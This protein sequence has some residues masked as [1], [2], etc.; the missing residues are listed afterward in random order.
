LDDNFYKRPAWF[1]ARSKAI[2]RWKSS[3]LPCAVCGQ[4]INWVVKGSMIVDHIVNRK[5]RPDL[6]LE[7]TNL[8]VVH[9]PCNTKKAL[10]K[11]NTTREEIGLDGLPASWR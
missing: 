2:A 3:G 7:P 11:E 6:A 1:K 4:P 9:H 10:W 5:K 8:Q